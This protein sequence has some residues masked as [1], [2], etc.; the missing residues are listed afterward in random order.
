[1]VTTKSEIAEFRRN[2]RNEIMN[3]VTLLK[4]VRE[5]QALLAEVV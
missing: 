2:L 5:N 1:M 3:H 4:K